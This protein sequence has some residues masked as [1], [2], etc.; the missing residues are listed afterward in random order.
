MSPL[1]ENN[2]EF[3]DHTFHT[4]NAS[5]E[6][7]AL[8]RQQL[9]QLAHAAIESTLSAIP[10]AFESP[11]A[12]LSEARGVFTTLYLGDQLRGC[13]GYVFPVAPLHQAVAETARAAAFHDPRFSAVT[14]EEAGNLSIDLSV[15]SLLHRASSEDVLVGV[16]G[17]VVSMHGRRGLLL[18]QVPLEH[19]WDRETFLA[20]TCIKA[21]L[22]ADAWQH[23]ALL[24]VFTAEVFG[25]S[26]KAR[27]SVGP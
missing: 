20:H 19:H 17:L 8:E 21:G 2:P 1:P 27:G 4:E 13:V 12:R 14:E 26:N 7:S 25:E 23:G 18:P 22:P 11:S 16:H 5:Q 3:S 15:L 10:L 24:E 6:F 9:L